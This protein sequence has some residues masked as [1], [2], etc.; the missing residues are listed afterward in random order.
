MRFRLV[1]RDTYMQANSVIWHILETLCM[2]GL[3]VYNLGKREEGRELAKK[4]LAQDVKSHVCWHVN[5]LIH[6]ADRDYED[7][8][9]CYIQGSRI[10][11]VSCRS[12]SRPLAILTIAHAERPEHHAR[13]DQS[14]AILAKVQ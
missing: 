9:K 5:A 2:K 8:L 6:R 10:E 12:A 13:Q 4:G 1:F 7:A 11:P 3:S 14:T